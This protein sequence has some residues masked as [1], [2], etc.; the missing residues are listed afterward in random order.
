MKRHEIREQFNLGGPGSGNRGH[1]GGAGGPGNP[2][3][4]SSK[5]GLASWSQVPNSYYYKI[6]PGGVKAMLTQEGETWSFEPAQKGFNLKHLKKTGLTQEQAVREGEGF[7]ERYKGIGTYRVGYSNK[8][9][10]QK[11]KNVIAPS[12]YVAEEKV[13]LWMKDFYRISGDSVKGVMR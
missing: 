8:S 1:T 5:G 11:Y 4:S 12:P 3:G 10:K 6:E 13:R 7:L 2:G 9:L